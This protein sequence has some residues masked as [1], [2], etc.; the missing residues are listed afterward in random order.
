MILDTSIKLYAQYVYINHVDFIVRIQF[1]IVS[2]TLS[3]IDNFNNY[4]QHNVLF[5]LYKN[6]IKTH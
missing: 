1:F 4:D 5:Y 3:N 6:Y 2:K